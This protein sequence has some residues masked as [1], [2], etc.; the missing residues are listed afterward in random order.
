[1]G[2]SSGD[3][4]CT[5]DTKRGKCSESHGRTCMDSF[6]SSVP[7]SVSRSRACD[8]S[9]RILQCTPQTQHFQL[10]AMGRPAV[11]LIEQE[12]PKRQFVFF[13]FAGG[14]SSLALGVYRSGAGI[15]L[16]DLI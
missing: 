13:G 16:T 1:M 7:Y 5:D 4:K 14:A 10:E 15:R 8:N 2:G 3:R 9:S 12:F 11:A 6:G